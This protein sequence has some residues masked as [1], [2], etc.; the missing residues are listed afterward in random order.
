[1]ACSGHALVRVQVDLLPFEAAPQA[2]DEDAIHRASPF[3]ENFRKV[4]HEAMMEAAAEGHRQGVEFGVRWGARA[5]HEY[6][7]GAVFGKGVGVAG[8]GVGTLFSQVAEKAKSLK[9]KDSLARGWKSMFGGPKPARLGQLN[10]SRTQY[11][12]LRRAT[13]NDE[14]SVRKYL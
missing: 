12:Q 3:G 4:H 7:V 1:M 2:F 14:D 5:G 9:V 11:K 13:P 6:V 8:Q 10:I